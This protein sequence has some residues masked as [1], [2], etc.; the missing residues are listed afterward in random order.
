MKLGAILTAM[1]ER[2]GF[3]QE[4]LAAKLNRSR[5][6]VTKLENNKQTLDVTTLVQWS[7]E[8][9]S[10]EVVVAFLCGMDGITIMQQLFQNVMQVTV[11]L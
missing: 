5:S 4:E 3:S 7:K 6:S 1:R 8:T 10:Q 11:G 9:S 2:A